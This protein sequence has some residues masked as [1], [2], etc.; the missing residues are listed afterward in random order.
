MS[1]NESHVILY[2]ISGTTNVTFSAQVSASSLGAA[3][4]AG[5]IA[6]FNSAT[7]ALV[8]DR[9]NN[10][11]IRVNLSTD[12]LT[13]ISVGDNPRGVAVNTVD[14]RAYVVNGDDRTV[15]IIDLSD[16][17]VTVG[18][19]ALGLDPVDI[20]INKGTSGALPVIVNT[21]DGSLTVF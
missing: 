6:L 9:D 10:Q 8:T 16:N 11:V 13:R 14:N 19:L 3:I 5:G 15:S 18:S 1:D 12:E 2:N 7:E 21:G 20:G 17:S 4:N